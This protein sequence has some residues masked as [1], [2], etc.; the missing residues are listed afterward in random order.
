MK[1]FSAQLLFII[2]LAGFGV[3]FGIDQAAKHDGKNPALV[4]RSFLPEIKAGLGDDPHA[5]NPA[6]VKSASSASN[7]E[8]SKSG[9][10]SVNGAGG[11]AAGEGAHGE[12]GSEAPVKESFMNRLGTK[13]GEVVRMA[14]GALVGLFV[15][16]AGSLLH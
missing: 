4:H 1:R 2:F 7:G 11:K 9:A 12:A 3:S 5:S 14:V 15:S 16:L 10:A 13:L 6:G 8:S